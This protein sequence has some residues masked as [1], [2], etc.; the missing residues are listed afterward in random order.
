MSLSIAADSDSVYSNIATDEHLVFFRTTA[1]LDAKR[2]EWHVPIHGW[3]Y[4]P[5]D[6]VMRKA[7]FSKILK[8]EYGLR[9]NS[10]TEANYKRR[11]NLLIADNERGKRIVVSV[12][13]QSY[14]LPRSSANGHFQK[15]LKISSADLDDAVENASLTF[16]AVTRKGDRRRFSGEV[17]FLRPEGLSIISDIDDT[18]KVSEIGDR[19]R[20]L[21]RTFLLDFEAVPGM[22][23]LY[24]DWADPGVGFHYVSSSPW[25]LYSPLEEFLA[26]SGFPKP[27]LHLKPVRFRDSTL[28]DLFKKG[29]E[30]KPAVIDDIL[31]NFPDRK[32]VL[33]GDSGEHDPEVYASF[34]R[35]YPDQI[36]KVMIRNVTKESSTNDRFSE[37]FEGIEPECWQL[38]DHPGE[39]QSGL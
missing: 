21:E 5:E 27:S 23:E 16:F 19:K 12:A 32:F 17:L 15:T 4:E 37:L 22:S 34:L 25:Q 38:F 20:L 3:I 11:L 18:V 6:S 29:T 13:G 2:Q 10:K 1:R 7:L 33:V 24:A 28:F 35:R 31:K 9:P 14:V 26:D 39:L 30:T 8:E 36:L